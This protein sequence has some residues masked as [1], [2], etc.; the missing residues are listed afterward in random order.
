MVPPALGA[1]V[2]S[3]TEVSDDVNEIGVVGPSTSSD[4]EIRTSEDQKIHILDHIL[5]IKSKKYRF[6]WR[7]KSMFMWK[8][9]E[10]KVEGA[11]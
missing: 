10:I 2:G 4:E 7:A 1:S 3:N 5:H 8:Q 6:N 9:L 11:K